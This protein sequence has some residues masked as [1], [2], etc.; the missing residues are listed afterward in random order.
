MQATW[1]T[2]DMPTLTSPSV[3][4]IQRPTLAESNPK[5]IQT[6]TSSWYLP[7]G[8]LNHHS[9]GKSCCRSHVIAAWHFIGA[10]RCLL[11][12]IKVHRYH[13]WTATQTTEARFL[14]SSKSFTVLD[15]IGVNHQSTCKTLLQCRPS[16]PILR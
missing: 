10:I 6:L 16:L 2:M 8:R 9:L 13:I 14:R 1:P 3:N 15:H 5:L 4:K 11:Y 7:L 12:N